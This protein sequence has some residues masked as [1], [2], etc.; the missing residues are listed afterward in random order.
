MANGRVILAHLGN[1]ASLAAVRDGRCLDTSMGFMPAA[2][3]VMERRSGDLDPGLVAYLARTEGMTA[4]QLDEFV[5]QK[6]GM[7]GVSETSSDMRELLALEGSDPRA[8]GAISLFCYQAKKWIGYFAAVLGGLDTLVFPVASAKTASP[9]AHASAQDLVFWAF[10]LNET[11]N[12]KHSTRISTDG[13]K[14]AVFMIRTDEELLMAKSAYRVI[15]ME[16]STGF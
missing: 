2:G 13:T 14:V 11:L 1:G 16:T 3:L 10:E 9:F 5:N 6:S 7:L 4:E 15:G 8:A 12:S